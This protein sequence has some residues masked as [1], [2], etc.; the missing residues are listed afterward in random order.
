MYEFAKVHHYMPGR[1]ITTVHDSC[2]DCML[3][4]SMRHSQP[5]CPPGTHLLAALQ[6]WKCSADES[7]HIVHE[8][9]KS[10]HFAAGILPI[11]GMPLAPVCPSVA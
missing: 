9:F 8:F 6:I 1:L 3:H 11:P 10:R 7:N 2:C 5:M 4:L